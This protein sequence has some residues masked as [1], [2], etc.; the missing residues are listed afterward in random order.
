MYVLDEDKM[1]AEEFNK[2][3]ERLKRLMTKDFSDIKEKRVDGVKKTN[4]RRRSHLMAHQKKKRTLIV[5]S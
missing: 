5:A 4:K 2:R 3:F 1:S